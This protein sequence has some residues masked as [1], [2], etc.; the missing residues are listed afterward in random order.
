MQENLSLFLVMNSVEDGVVSI[1]HV[2][3]TQIQL[4]ER[5]GCTV[6]LGFVDDRTS[7]GGI[8]RNIRKLANQIERVN[9]DLVIAHYGSVTSA[10]AR[11]AKGNRPFIVFF[12][13]SDILGTAEP[14]LIWRVRD[15]LTKWMGIW[16]AQAAQR[17]IVNGE[18]ICR[19]LPRWLI[20]RVEP[21]PN[22]TDVALFRPLPRDECRLNL[23]WDLE[24]R[25]ALFNASTGS[26]V[27]IKN[28]ALARE[29]IARVRATLPNVC[30]HEISTA[31]REEV[32]LLM[33]AA[34]CLLVT[35]FHE[36]SPDI[37]K[38]ALACNLPVVSVPCG[39]VAERLK[40]TDPSAIC[41]YDASV[42]A[43]AV[44]QIF[45]S[46]AR[47]NGRQQL[48][49]QRLDADSITQRLLSAFE[50]AIDQKNASRNRKHS[51]TRLERRA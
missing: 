22:G 11:I 41:P 17:V 26:S 30:L 46:G 42:L 5:A 49:A 12:R 13:G 7:V 33:N 9:P 36:G 47:S 15:R 34:D 23:G 19:A 44:S 45:S 1:P 10:V 14:G 38:E 35:S 18:G 3:Q 48:L 16:A 25:V 21:I 29:T 27:A 28:P 43:N 32:A 2:F 20:H 50:Q 40:G 39:D 8:I 4:L 6:H 37:V 24:T 31:T 51:A